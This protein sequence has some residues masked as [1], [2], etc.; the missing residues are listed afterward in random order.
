MS[1]FIH[2]E[3]GWVKEGGHWLHGHWRDRLSQIEAGIAETARLA[4]SE[5]L[6]TIAADPKHLGAEIGF[7]AVLHSWGQTLTHHPHIHCLVP[8]P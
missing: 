4:V 8:L 2:I 7:L 6:R 5:T 3:A 1:P